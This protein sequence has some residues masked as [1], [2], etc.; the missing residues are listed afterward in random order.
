MEKVKVGILGATGA[1]GQRFIELLNDH[2]WFEIYSLMASSNSSGKKYGTA[3]NWILR[4]E[5]PS[6]IENMI[7][8]DCVPGDNLGL[9]FSG[10]EANAAKAIEMDFVKAG[11]PVVSNAKT[12]RMFDNIPLVIPEINFDHLK[13]ILQQKKNGR[14]GF[15]V[16]NPNC[17]AIPLT[18]ALNPLHQ[19]FGVEKVIVT[20]MQAVSGA[21]YPG[22][23][24]LDI[25]DNIIPYIEGEEEK[26][27][28]EPLKILGT[29][30]TE[31][32]EFA[33]FAISAR[34]HRVPVL[35]AHCL[36]VSVKLR[37]SNV[38][39][40]ELIQCYKHY[41]NPISQYSLPSSPSKLIYMSEN[42]DRP[43][44][45]ETETSITG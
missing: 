9:V 39:Q 5:I 10:L 44:R 24:A 7:I 36:A 13:L 43:H 29:L 28:I 3:V 40:A 22:V 20:T 38:S 23:S 2:P 11:I 14:K 18:I 21:G 33:D 8:Q 31:K 42:D 26:L 6:R 15:I 37:N 35:D 41:K 27:E 45:G 32:I 17:C 16:T 30:K 34:C 25:L 19:E 4:N 12:Y 1:V